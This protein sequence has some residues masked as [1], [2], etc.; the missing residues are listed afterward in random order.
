MAL[1]V[2]RISIG[3]R[4]PLLQ[5][6]GDALAASED[7]QQEDWD[8]VIK[9][10][11]PSVFCIVH[12]RSEYVFDHSAQV[13]DLHE[14]KATDTAVLFPTDQGEFVT[15]SD[16]GFFPYVF[17]EYHLS[18]FV[19]AQYCFHHKPGDRVASAG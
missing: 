5:L 19:N 7:E 15:G 8:A 9:I 17:W 1:S 4:A 13:L 3:R 2:V 11:S 12:E 10:R 16:A 18:T 14:R 6:H